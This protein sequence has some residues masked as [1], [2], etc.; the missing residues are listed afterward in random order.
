MREFLKLNTGI[1]ILS[2]IRT[3][4]NLI[5]IYKILFLQIHMMLLDYFQIYYLRVIQTME[6]KYLKKK[7]K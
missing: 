7:W 1:N 2:I 5:I 3:I 6:K 4:V